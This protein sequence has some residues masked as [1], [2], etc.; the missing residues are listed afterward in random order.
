MRRDNLVA[1][2][3]QKSLQM[4]TGQSQLNQ[5]D[6]STYIYQQMTNHPLRINQNPH[7]LSGVWSVLSSQLSA[8]NY[9]QINNI[10][11]VSRKY[12]QNSSVFNKRKSRSSST[13]SNQQSK[14]GRK[15]KLFQQRGKRRISYCASALRT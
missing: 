15:Q 3:P 13:D 8:Q 5:S 6:Y 2:T 4:Q 9:S 11:L 12:Y 14:N 7:N 1:Q 10:F